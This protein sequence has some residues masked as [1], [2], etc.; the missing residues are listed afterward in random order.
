M[1]SAHYNL[2]DC[3]QG[4]GSLSVL[5]CD[6]T[7]GHDADC[8]FQAKQIPQQSHIVTPP[9][10]Q[11]GRLFNSLV[12]ATLTYIG[13]VL[14]VQTLAAKFGGDRVGSGRVFHRPQRP[15]LEVTVRWICHLIH[16]CNQSFHA[17]G[18]PSTLTVINIPF[19]LHCDPYLNYKLLTNRTI[20]N[21][22]LM[23][24]GNSN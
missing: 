21:I 8:K 12:R 7:V 3:S 18:Q 11:E 24:S 4:Q 17:L 15:Q 5:L 19:R 20:G 16:V 23:L 9:K 1:Q 13:L 22:S 6:D 14:C 10:N 2:G